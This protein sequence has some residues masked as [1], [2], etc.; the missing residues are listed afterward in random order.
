M[1]MPTRV[2]LDTCCLNRPFDAQVG[3]RVRL[4]TAA[5]LSVL[6]RIRSGRVEWLG[7]T[8]LLAEL[9]RRPDG[10]P[11]GMRELLRYMRR[12]VPV[13]GAEESRARQWMALGLHAMDALHVACA[14]AGHASVI[15][16]TDDRV[17]RVVR[18]ASGIAHVPARNPREWIGGIQP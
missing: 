10:P 16:T 9:A 4:E 7:S 3:E 1:T 6:D 15:L 5:V 14:E 18:R 17:L 12:V 13:S 2:Y 8:V 11:E